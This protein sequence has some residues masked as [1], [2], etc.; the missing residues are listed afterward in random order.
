MKKRR[1]T[2]EALEK[3]KKE[4]P[5]YSNPELAVRYKTSAKSIDYY[6]QKFNLKKSADTKSRIRSIAGRKGGAKR[7]HSR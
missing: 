4:Y 1:I 2:D 7:W 5:D 3:L 6:A